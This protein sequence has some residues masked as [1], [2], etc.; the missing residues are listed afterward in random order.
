MRE[1]AAMFRAGWLGALS[2]RANMLFSLFALSLTL[3]P[4]YFVAQA[5]Q[6]VAAPSIRTEGG[7]YLG[8]LMLGLMLLA[9]VQTS[10][11]ALPQ[12]IAGGIGSGTFEALLTTPVRLPIVLVGMISY[13]I[14][15]ALVRA[16]IMLGAAVVL[17]V[18]LNLTSLPG[19]FLALVFTLAS[20][21]GISLAL[22]GM[23]LVFRSTGPLTSGIVAASAL[24]GG[25][26]YSTTVIPSWIQ[27]LSAIIPLTYGLRAFRQALLVGV[28]F[29]ELW[30]DLLTVA[31]FA[32]AALGIGGLAL[33]LALQHA[34]REGTLGQY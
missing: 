34:R 30:P 4:V 2:Y 20:Y 17:G 5:L 22:A 29:A 28:P 10:L 3:A 1:L 12:A 11:S 33:L 25:A 14:S 32:I 15:W 13:E 9:M 23:I 27:K 6:S 7:H 19:A 16:L 8:F 18:S 26:Y 24:L 21:F 31:A